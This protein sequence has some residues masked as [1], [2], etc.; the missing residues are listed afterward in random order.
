MK[1]M[2]PQI[3]D[4]IKRIREKTAEASARYP[5]KNGEVR[6]MAV[7]KTVDPELINF[8]VHNGFDL[9]GENR[10]QEYLSKKDS[11]DPA[12]KVHFIGNLQTNKVKYIINEVEM[13]QSVS[14]IKLANEINRLAA[15]NNKVMDV[16]LEVN[17]GSELTKGGAAPDQLFELAREASLLEN[18]HVRGLMAI[19]PV[20]CGEETFAQMNELF[21]KLGESGIKGIDMDILSMGMSGDYELAIKHGSNLV[22]IGTAL[23]G[24]RNYNTEG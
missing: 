17:I 12:A 3:L 5:N 7:T 4:N 9:L 10:V 13:I 15:K 23:F 1:Q 19:P 8:A 18:I 11:Y 6:I 14:G 2:Y 24:A 22:R 21:Q 16:L 20:G